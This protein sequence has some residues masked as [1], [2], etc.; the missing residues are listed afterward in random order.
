MQTL[1]GNKD[2][3]VMGDPM[4]VWSIGPTAMANPSSWTVDKA[5]QL[6]HFVEVCDCLAKSDWISAKC[7][8]SMLASKDGGE[9][10]IIGHE[11]PNVLLLNSVLAFVRQ[12]VAKND[13]LFN[14]AVA[15]YLEHASDDGKKMWVTQEQRWFRQTLDKPPFTLRQKLTMTGRK[16]LDLYFYPF[17]LLHVPKPSQVKEFREAI[18]RHRH[19]WLNVGLHSTMQQLVS[20]AH[21]VSI[22]VKQDLAGWIK[23][24]H[25]APDRINI[26]DV[27]GPHD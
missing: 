11:S 27:L 26:T 19:Q 4:S 20:H 18:Q 22:V 5:N 21:N 6:D 9:P 14:T 13:D 25:A 1:T 12:L 16:L 17:G 7:S 10:T 23:D 3:I 24:G 2:I 8:V 15:A